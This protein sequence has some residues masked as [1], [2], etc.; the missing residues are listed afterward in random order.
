MHSN[1]G[2]P[3]EQVQVER[4]NGDAGSSALT[5]DIST[6]EQGKKAMSGVQRDEIE[7]I[8]SD[9]TKEQQTTG[10]ASDTLDPEALT[11]TASVQ[12]PLYSVFSKNEKLFIVL[13]AALGAFFSPL[14]G[15]I[16]FPALNSLA[17]HLHVSNSLI[18]LTIT[19]YMVC[20]V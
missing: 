2:T 6:F 10:M 11:T 14:S 1:N 3:G 13:M 9:Q 18:N 8:S 19:S 5:V 15:T 4:A 20:L 12:P 7:Q 17:A 16:Y